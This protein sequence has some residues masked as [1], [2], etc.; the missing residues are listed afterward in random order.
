MIRTWL[1]GLRL[2]H[3]RLLVHELGE[4]QRQLD[5]I[6]SLR[7]DCPG[8]RIASGVRLLSFRPALISI[9]ESASIGEGTILSCGDDNNGFG[10][11][12]IGANTWIGQYNNLRAGGGT[13]RIG[14]DCLISQFCTLVASNHGVE[15]G[16]PIRAQPPEATRRGVTLGDDVWLGAGV[17]VMPGVTIGT[18][19]VIAAN[20]VVTHD[21][22]GHEIWGGVPARRIGARE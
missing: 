3:S 6:E 10:R 9:G 5:E 16:T 21:V 14:R 2:L 19:S 7:K 15:R 12:E 22:P 13:I 8:A 4:R 11:I 20:A 18:G 17:A 1:R